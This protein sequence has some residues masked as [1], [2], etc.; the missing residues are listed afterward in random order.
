[1]LRILIAD[2]NT[3]VRRYIHEALEDE[4]GWEVCGEAA[5]GRE[6]VNMT[7]ALKPDIVVLDVSMPEVNGL[8]AAERIHK[9][10]PGT[11]ILILSMYDAP[12]LIEAALASG[13]R[14][15]LLKHEL[16]ELVET[17]REVLKIPAA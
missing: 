17:V 12:E 14:A 1:M 7:A 15:Y 2:D 3:M 8:E 13:A 11:E 4:T 9:Q 5:T 16:G 10:F 6:A